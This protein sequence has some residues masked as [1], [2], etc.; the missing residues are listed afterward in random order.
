[1]SVYTPVTIQDLEP[2]TR[3]RGLGQ[4]VNLRGITAGVD[5]TNYQVTTEKGQYVLTLVEDKHQGEALPYVA[6]VLKHLA[7]LGIPCPLP[8][9]DSNGDP[10]FHLLDHPAILVAFLPGTSPLAPTPRQCQTIG[11]WLGRIHLAAAH[12]PH[13]RKNPRGEQKWIEIIKKITPSLAH[14]QPE[15]L[16]LVQSELHWLK[17]NFLAASLQ[18]GLCHADLFPDNTLFQENQTTGIIDFFFACDERF[19]YDLA[20][21]LCAWC[22]PGQKT[23]NR[24]LW[25]ELLS[26][27]QTVRPLD[28]AE[29][30]FL[31]AALRAAALRF[32]LTRLHDQIFPRSGQQVTRKDPEE[33]IAK[34]RFFQNCTYDA[35]LYPSG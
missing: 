11:E 26:G 23:P 34:L 27:Y 22:F 18:H 25:N 15:W 16:A 33:F 13:Q 32:A 35:E 3:L 4:I 21:C 14:T 5:N 31:G 17:K 24:Q 7:G 28:A 20:I 12:F 19:I 10:L 8:A 2:Y 9:E 30:S 29:M 1:M 6:Q